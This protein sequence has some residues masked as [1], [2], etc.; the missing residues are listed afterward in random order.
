MLFR[1]KTAAQATGC[2]HLDHIVQA[3]QQ[4]IDPLTCQGVEQLPV[5]EK[6]SL[7]NAVARR[8][9][10]RVV[11][12][13]ARESETLGGLVRDGRIAVVGA[14]YDVVTG[15]IEFLTD[16]AESP[17]EGTASVLG[18]PGLVPMLSLH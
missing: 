11:E 7:V 14:M 17:V 15:N 18:V 13:L 6:E 3:I 8:N 10:A 2:Q 9:V 1:S 4:S 5:L 16:P 12:M